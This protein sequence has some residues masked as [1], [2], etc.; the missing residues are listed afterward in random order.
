M[1]GVSLAGGSL[2]DREGLSPV[3]IAEEIEIGSDTDMVS[4]HGKQALPA[5]REIFVVT[6]AVETVTGVRDEDA[7]NHAERLSFL[8]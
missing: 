7:D 4:D 6:D 8:P 5:A 2:H 1:R 3:E